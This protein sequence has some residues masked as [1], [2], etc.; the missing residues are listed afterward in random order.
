[1]SFA[2]LVRAQLQG[3]RLDD[4][5]VDG[6]S[7]YETVLDAD[8]LAPTRAAYAP[9]PVRF[10]PEELTPIIQTGPG[11]VRSLAYSPDGKLLAVASQ[12]NTTI[13]IFDLATGQ[14]RRVLS[15]HTAGVNTL[16]W[17]PDGQQLASGAV[18]GTVR[19]WAVATGQMERI[20]EGHREAVWAV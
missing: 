12:G 1:L 16:C 13:R 10:D 9:D 8:Q 17:R 20:L 7:F 2:T 11:L 18:D 3:A 19:L 15:G 5:V 6:T 4:A 14:C